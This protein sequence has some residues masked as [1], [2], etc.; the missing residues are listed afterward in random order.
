MQSWLDQCLKYAN[1]NSV[2]IL[3][4][5]QW[6]TFTEARQD[7]KFANVIWDNTTAQLRFTLA[8]TTTPSLAFT[9]MIPLVHSG[10]SLKT[11]TVDGTP[12]PYS[13]ELVN[14]VNTG[15]VSVA[16]GSAN[17]VATYEADTALT[18]VTAANS[19]PQVL[20]KTVAFT[21]T[22][23]GGSNPNY[24]WQFGDG[25]F[26]SGANTTHAFKSYPLGGTQVVTLTASNGAGSVVMTT[27][28]SLLLP[29][30]SYLPLVSKPR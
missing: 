28:V 16:S 14:G 30:Q 21:A 20:F 17:I 12:T 4:A 1:D 24:V 11:V 27:T 9:I 10:S 3:N 8:A 6:A 18:G 19:S 15:F 7:G 13:V 29:P 25:E 22:V 23:S 2:P 5:G 26:G